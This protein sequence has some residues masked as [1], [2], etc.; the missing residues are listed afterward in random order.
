M[1]R[2]QCEIT[3]QRQIEGILARGR[4]GRL[5][6]LGEDGYPYITPVNY[7]FWQDT[8]YFHCSLQ[9]EKLDNIRRDGKVCFEVDIPL[10]YLDTGYDSSMA[11]CD[12]GQ[13]YQSVIIRGRAEIVQNPEEKVDALNALMASHENVSAFSAITAET[14]AV[15]FCEVV[16]VRVESLSAKANLGQKK[17]PSEKEKIRNYLRQRGSARGYGS[18]GSDP[19]KAVF[20]QERGEDMHLVLGLIVAFLGAVEFG[21]SGA[22]IGGFVGV[23]AA[24]VL[25]L[26]KRLALLE[27]DKQKEDGSMQT[28]GREVVFEPLDVEPVAVSPPRSGPTEPRR[29]A[30]RS[31]KTESVKPVG[32][33]T[34]LDR[35]FDGLGGRAAKFA[36]RAGAFFT[37]GN[38]V[39]KIGVIVLFFGVAFLLKYAAQR[40]MI[41]IE[42]R[43]VGVALSGMVLL[44]LG[45][46]LRRIRS[47]YGLV[48]QGGGVGIL[49]L[50]VFAAA[51]LYN[52]LPI[53]L[54]L[55]VMIG[56]VA[57]SCMLAVL[58]E[59]KSLA[60]F[61]VVGGFLAPVLMSDGGGSHVLLFS[62][63]ALLNAGIFSIA[64]FK[65]WRELNLIGFLFTFGIGTLW[66]STG[67]QPEFFLSTEPFLV[68][69]FVFYVVI[70]VL[71]AHRQEVKLRGY[72]DGP[73]VFGLPLI[74]SGLQYCLVKDF[75]YGMA[76]SALAL[77]L[78]YLT[79]A[80]VLW[81]KLVLSMHLLCEAFLALGVVFGSLAIPLALDGHWSAAIWALEGAGMVWVGMR[82]KRVLARHFGLLL[83]LSAAYIFLDSVWYPFSAIA[84][85][86]RYF[87]GCLFLS[88]AAFFSCYC[89]DKYSSELK[90]WERYYSMPLMVL[91]LVW[92]Y[93]A[94][95]REV[96]MQ[97]QYTERTDG[98]L[99][100]CCLGSVLM[101]MVAKKLQW[102]RFQ[103]SLYLQLPA[104]VVLSAISFVDAS[105]DFH[106]F[107]GWGAVA[108]TVAFVV[109]Y[110]ILYLFAEQWPK[111]NM[112]VWHLVTM[113]LL[114]F[115]LSNEGSWAVGRIPG[116]AHIWQTICWAVIPSGALLLILHLG[117]GS[118]W[119]VGKYSADYLGLGCVVP[120]FGLFLWTI[121]SFALAGNPSPL[122]YVPL[123][124]PLELS[125]L[126]VVAV[127]LLWLLSCKSRGDTLKLLPV[128]PVFV[129][130]ALLF[131][132][133]LNSVVARSVHFYVGIPYHLDS[134][135]HSV[136]FQAALAALWGFGALAITIWATRKGSRMLWAVGAAL[137]GLVV[138]KLFVV[139]LS[140]TGTIAR[141][142]SFLVV[143]I[144]MLIIG[145]FSPIPPQKGETS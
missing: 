56:L 44:G 116:L 115:I 58:Q 84:F 102:P 1:R 16:A 86:N 120:G 93:I 24:E 73:L 40:N 32:Q 68:L 57:L 54:S 15:K 108:W 135:Y 122:P 41:P 29:A 55:A 117:K 94:G 13:F 123:F 48:L 63:Y 99:L 9:G 31:K 110:R 52:F 51:K 43:L 23:L 36:A 11:V 38:V 5:A 27:K 128:K 46:W 118:S 90:K 49:Y 45:W 133:W 129:A 82:Q 61:G 20:W 22:L 47:G 59:A 100:Y 14:P 107:H 53:S 130:L 3:E 12:V 25:S 142:I 60:I 39:L 28:V 64:W 65:S 121:S 34:S 37:T 139:D 106:L 88:L 96:D 101:G 21:I 131:F 112:I 126:V 144:L 97:L 30:P 113:W 138:L 104:M 69:F 125:G 111:R 137:I 143:G 89:L 83:Q 134:L 105:P 109:Q 136:I 87:L 127:L 10:A 141:I 74:V 91:G 124:N 75:Q 62:Y 78:F 6:T 17:S 114:I 66:G 95:L 76:F 79:L 140:G 80:T 70:S 77:G 72:I 98:F 81:R 33:P 119:P 103:L 8:I 7:V 85:A 71:F 67:Y 50:V 42:L 92:W 19:L 132:F 35:F 145:Y 4:V 2:K 18:G 26:R